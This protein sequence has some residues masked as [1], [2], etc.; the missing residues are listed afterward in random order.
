LLWRAFEFNRANSGELRCLASNRRSE[1]VSRR[2][3]SE[4]MGL[5]CQQEAP[6]VMPGALQLIRYQGAIGQEHLV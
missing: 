2:V 4:F 3:L 1:E 6:R 5:G